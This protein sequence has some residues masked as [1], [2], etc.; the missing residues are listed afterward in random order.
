MSNPIYLGFDIGSSSVHYA[1]L[2]GQGQILHAS[3]PIMHF[4]D[5]SDA[6]ARLWAEAV[7]RFG[8]ESIVSTAFTGSGARIFGQNL[9]GLLYEYESVTIPKGVRKAEPEADFV[10]HIGAKD[11]YFFHLRDQGEELIIQDWAAGTKCGGG[12]GMLLEKQCRRLFEELIPSEGIDDGLFKP[13]QLRLERMF[14]R[15]EEE[16]REAEAGEEF[17]AR[18]GVVIQSDLIHEQNTGSPRSHNL[19][20]LFKTVARNFKND[21]ITSMD[22]NG[23]RAVGTGGV[24]ANDLIRVE[25]GEFTGIEIAPCRH[26]SAVG[27]LGAACRGLDA[28][29]RY[30][31][32]PEKFNAA[33]EVQKGRRQFAPALTEALELVEAAQEDLDTGILA[34]ETDVLLGIDGG[35]TT[36]KGVLVALEDG[37]LLDKIYLKTHGNP[38][39]SLKKVMRHL[40]RHKDRVSVKGVAATGSARR[41]YERI[42]MSRARGDE[43]T[44]KGGVPVDTVP[45]EITCHA[46]GVKFHNA[47]IDTVFEIGG[48]DMKFTTFRIENGTVTDNVNRAEMNYSCQAGSGQTLEN[49]ASVIDLQVEDSLQEFALRAERV[50]IIDSTC[51]VFMEMDV[52]R[53][54]GEHFSREEIAAAIIRATAASYYYKFV[55][56]DQHVGQRCSAQGGPALGTAFL[57][58]LAQVTERTIHAFPHREVFGAWGAAL[59]VR[60]QVMD[61]IEKGNKIETAFR[62]WELVDMDLAKSSTYCRDLLPDQSCTRR[63]CMLTRYNIGSDEIL[64]G[65]FCPLGNSENAARPRTNY[66]DVFH[67]VFEKH[68]RRFG[69]LQ[70]DLDTQADIPEDTIGIKRCTSTLGEKGIWSAAVWAHLGYTPVL[71]PLSNDRIAKNGVNNSQTDFCIARKLATGHAQALND[72]PRVRYF[73]NPSFISYMHDDLRQMK[74]CIYT[75]SEGYI[76]ND[77]LALDKQFQIN[78]ILNFGDIDILAAAFRTELR[79]VGRPVSLRKIKAAIRH[80]D[81]MEQEFRDALARLG[82]IFL[83]R[84]EKEDATGFVGIGRDYVVLD[85]KAC[86]DAGRMLSRTRGLN[87]IPQIFLRHLFQHIPIE[88][89]VEKEYWEQSDTILRCDLFVAEHPRLF[90]IR[91]LNFGCGPDSMKLFQEE[92]IFESASKPLL[93]FLTDAQTNNAPFVTRTEAHERVVARSQPGKVDPARVS[94]KRRSRKED[95]VER[96]WLIAYMGDDSYMGSAVLHH[97]NVDSRVLPTRTAIGHE[98]ANKHIFT[99]VC[100]P[101]KGV[102]GDVLSFLKIQ[103]RKHGREFVNRS[104]LIMIPSAGGPCRFGKYRELLRIFMDEEG[105]NG[106]PIEGPSSEYDYCDISLPGENGTISHNKLIGLLYRGLYAADLLEDIT[107]RYRP[108]ARVPDEVDGLKARRLKELE[109][110]ISQG[111]KMSAIQTWAEETV[112]AFKRLDVIKTERYPLVLYMGE[113]YMRHH[114]PYTDNVIRLLEEKKLEVI[115][116]PVYE[117]LHYINEMQHMRMS[118]SMAINFRNLHPFRWG[119]SVFKLA[120]AGLRKH[121]LEKLEHRI[122]APFEEVLAGRQSASPTPEEI[123]R[124]LEA[125]HHFHSNIEGEAPLSIGLAYFFMIDRFRNMPAQD[126][127]ISGLFHVGPFTCMQEGVATAKMDV[128]IKEYRKDHPDLLI[129]MVHAFFGDSPNPNLEAEIAVFREQCYQKRDRLR[130]SAGRAAAPQ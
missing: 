94:V 106:V 117:W 31:L 33:L 120:E 19:A 23:G 28:D 76:L 127:F 52:N 1:A 32:E 115:R 3:Q 92:K 91:M 84:L 126:A 43:I 87:Y 113:I 45:D 102:V 29:N 128:M 111:G 22:F 98:L 81:Q 123:I 6:Y 114:D 77:A 83:A 89:L 48:Q 97:F 121:Y 47:D 64:T 40:A 66:I 26:Y 9:D 69:L 61:Q 70:V 108:Y 11:P 85:P 37:R 60:G 110:C 41:F 34:R 56:G 107:L 46:L 116:S 68:F 75:E 96:E 82:D 15:A 27:A 104:Y 100:Y 99:E 21:V 35:S 51:G 10:F 57:A 74:Y 12:S 101:L 80:A 118:R 124:E 109:A 73:F 50:P 42:L 38:E 67:A 58:G 95:L 86:S 65:G 20:R 62:G 78:T 103:E 4:A 17:L 7:N 55:G 44:E 54:I 49:L 130:T 71:S 36:T 24:M 90:P 79:R 8:R 39:E 53:L 72:D 105:F 5:I 2:D 59:H 25:L 63:D 14:K 16:A 13:E 125:G 119:R 18:C 122:S 88:H 129:P 112:R 30:V 93:T